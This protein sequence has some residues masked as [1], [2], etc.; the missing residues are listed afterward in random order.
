MD[1]DPNEMSFAG[2]AEEENK[3]TAEA[4]KKSKEAP[5]DEHLRKIIIDYI[6]NNLINVING[7]KIDHSLADINPECQEIIEA[8]SAFEREEDFGLDHDQQDM[9]EFLKDY[10][11]V[12]AKSKTKQKLSEEKLEIIFNVLSK[13]GYDKQYTILALTLDILSEVIKKDVIKDMIARHNLEKRAT[14]LTE[15]IIEFKDEELL[16]TNVGSEIN[17]IIDKY[18]TLVNIKIKP[19]DEALINKIKTDLNKII[20]LEFQRMANQEFEYARMSIIEREQYKQRLEKIKTIK[21]E[22][23]F[24]LENFGFIGLLLEKRQAD[25]MEIHKDY[26]NINKR[27]G[28]YLP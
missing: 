2:F 28:Q 5:L 11:Q 4:R 25:I 24:N 8:L 3:K 9:F 27:L 26:K 20:E 16:Y 13:K 17:K 7:Q 19:K 14:I 23:V 22:E 1:M 15:K 6:Y 21:A 10:D 18:K 12:K